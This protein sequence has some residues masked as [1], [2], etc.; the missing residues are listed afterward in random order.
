MNK[1]FVIAQILLI[2]LLSVILFVPSQRNVEDPAALLAAIAL[3]EIMYL[4]QLMRGRK[5]GKAN[6]ALSDIMSLI[7]LFLLVWEIFVTKLNRMQPVLFPAAEDVFNVFRTQYPRLLGNVVSSLQLL[8][9]GVFSGIALGG[10]LGLPMGWFP[11]LRAIC[12]PIANVLAPIPSVVFAPY[13]IALMPTFRSAS[14]LVVF[15][16][17]FWPT[18]LNTINRVSSIEKGI[19]DSARVLNVSN[20]TMIT[21][22]LLPYILPG[23]IGSLKV[24]LTTSM[25]MLTFAEMMGA[26]SGMGFYIISYTH[27]ANYTNV[28][29]GIIVVG[30]VVTIL[31]RLVTAL[32]KKVI[33]WR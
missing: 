4:F 6:P 12:Y 24:T 1:S 16:G 10:G 3:M 33:V 29:A 21:R 31:S 22:I 26:T 17:I 18:L 15:L 25:M 13:L 11:R 8:F 20:A 5:K 23:V 9:V 27:Y 14:A 32:Q 7:W 30:I 28:I 2:A 19:L